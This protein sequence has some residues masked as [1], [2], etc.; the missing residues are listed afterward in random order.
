M[1]QKGKSKV[2]I[3]SLGCPRNL[4]DSEVLLGTLKRDGFEIVDIYEADIGIVNTCAFI[5][6]AKKESIDMIMELTAL[7]KADRLRTIVVAGCMAQRYGR[8]L[9]KTLPEVDVFIGSDQILKISHV[10]KNLKKKTDICEISKIPSFIY[11]HTHPRFF[12]TP[13]HTIHIFRP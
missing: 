6:D 11:D 13:N 12:I 2:G 4:V 8:D 5:E 9:Q 1:I 10:L 3:I 7:K